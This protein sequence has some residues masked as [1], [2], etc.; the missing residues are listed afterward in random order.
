MAGIHPHDAAGVGD[1]E[2]EEISKI[3]SMP[4][5]VGIGEIGLDYY[6]D[7]SQET[8]RSGYSEL[9]WSLRRLLDVRYRSIAEMLILRRSIS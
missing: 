1:D 2:L 6:R 4:R 7:F 3:L 5:V 8:S 9:S